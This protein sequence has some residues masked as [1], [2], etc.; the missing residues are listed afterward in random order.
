ME[1]F[2]GRPVFIRDSRSVE[3]T[4]DGAF[5]LEHARRMLAMNREAVARFVQPEVQGVVRLGAPDDCAERFLPGMLRRF[6]ESHP[7]VTVNVAVV[8]AFSAAAPVTAPMTNE[9]TSSSRLTSPTST[10]AN[11]A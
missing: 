10:G 9:G 1:E 6:A 5:L 8:E 7:R 4:P 3:L 2:L 11:A